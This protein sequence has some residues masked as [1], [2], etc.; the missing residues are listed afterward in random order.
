MSPTATRAR[1]PPVVASATP[2]RTAASSTRRPACRCACRRCMR[3][4]GCRA[5][6]ACRPSSTATYARKPLSP[7]LGYPYSTRGLCLGSRHGI[8]GRALTPAWASA[9]ERGL[10]IAAHHH[11]AHLIRWLQ[12]VA[13]LGVP[14]AH[15]G[16][17]RGREHLPDGLQHL[18][19]DHAG[20]SRRSARVGVLCDS[21][22][23]HLLLPLSRHSI[24]S[25]SRRHSLLRQISSSRSGLARLGGWQR[26]RCCMRRAHKSCWARR[27]G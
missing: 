3:S 16:V 1:T 18:G 23:S 13:G 14:R 19:H 8:M 5:T 6:R 20:P 9:A 24:G 2:T 27:T 15:R 10:Q 26:T 21:H 22:R 7:R 17:L 25:G 4:L 11:N 12:V